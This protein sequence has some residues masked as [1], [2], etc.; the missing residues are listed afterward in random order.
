MFA[1]D[2]GDITLRISENVWSAGADNWDVE[3]VGPRTTIR[4]GKGLISLVLKAEP[5]TR[6]IVERLEMEFEEVRLKVVDGALTFASGEQRWSTLNGCSMNN[7]AVGIKIASRGPG[8]WSQAP[9]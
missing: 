2:T 8:A 9:G 6:L 4:Y 5:P 7:C 1:D 3:C